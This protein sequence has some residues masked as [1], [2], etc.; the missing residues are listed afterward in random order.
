MVLVRRLLLVVPSAIVVASCG[1]LDADDP[2]KAP[3]A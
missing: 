1:G 3:A 2:A